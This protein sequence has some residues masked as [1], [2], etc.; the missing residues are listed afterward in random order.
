LIEIK[1]E[2]LSK[3]KEVILKNAISNFGHDIQPLFKYPS[4]LYLG[5]YAE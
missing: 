3:Y 1:D 2:E 5:E 4:D